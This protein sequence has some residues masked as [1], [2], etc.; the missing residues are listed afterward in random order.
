MCF[1]HKCVFDINKKANFYKLEN[2][3]PLSLISNGIILE[4]GIWKGIKKKELWV[5]TKQKSIKH[6]N[7]DVLCL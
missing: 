6:L 5:L 7:P 3:G 2:S 1:E 4:K